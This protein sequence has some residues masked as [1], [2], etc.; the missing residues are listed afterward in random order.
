MK[1]EGPKASISPIEPVLTIGQAAEV[2]QVSTK[3]IRRWIAS[4]QLRAVKLGR[5]W[6]IHRRDLN[7][8]LHAGIF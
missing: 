6:R 4:G 1:R 7:A 2:C 8:A 3:T 5:Q